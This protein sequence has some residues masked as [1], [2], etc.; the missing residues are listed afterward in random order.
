VRD[1]GD[2]WSG[3]GHE[4]LGFLYIQPGKGRDRV[5]KEGSGCMEEEE[6]R[7]GKRQLET[8]IGR[9]GGRMV[10]RVLESYEDVIDYEP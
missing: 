4:P 6:A 7:L 5:A 9:G 8:E 2:P 1:G 10:R 3:I